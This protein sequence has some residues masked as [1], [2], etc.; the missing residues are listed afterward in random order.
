MGKIKSDFVRIFFFHKNNE[1]EEIF[2]KL[3]IGSKVTFESPK[4]AKGF[5]VFKID[6]IHDSSCNKFFYY[7]RNS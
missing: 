5:L 2:S 7:Y 1:D 6:V 4:T 3:K